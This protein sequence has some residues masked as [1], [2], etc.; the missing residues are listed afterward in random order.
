MEQTYGAQSTGLAFTVNTQTDAP[1]LNFASLINNARGFDI[2]SFIQFGYYSKSINNIN[3][4]IVYNPHKSSSKS[5]LF[6]AS[7]GIIHFHFY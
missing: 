6:T 5:A 1:F 7:F 4:N 2:W 3:F